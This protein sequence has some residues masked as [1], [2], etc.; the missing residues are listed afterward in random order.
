MMSSNLWLPAFVQNCM[1]KILLTGA[2]FYETGKVTGPPEVH[3][4]PSAV[5]NYLNT[6]KLLPDLERQILEN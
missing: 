1:D 5:V 2:N 4:E 6:L 3:Y